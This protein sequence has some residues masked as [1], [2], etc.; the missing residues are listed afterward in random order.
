MDKIQ[1]RIFTQTEA[2]L[3]RAAKTC[4]LF[5]DIAA[6]EVEERCCPLYHPRIKP[7]NNLLVPSSY[8]A[9]FSAIAMLQDNFHFFCC[10]FF[11]TLRFWP[12]IICK[13]ETN[14]ISQRLEWQL[15]LDSIRLQKLCFS[16]HRNVTGC[17]RVTHTSEDTKLWSSTW[18]I[19]SELWPKKLIL[20]YIFM[21]KVKTYSP[22]VSIK[23]KKSIYYFKSIFSK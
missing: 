2:S 1:F 12:T 13:W 3:K 15:H 7:V 8:S 6:K 9:H 23:L 22:E 20:L 18:V 19:G 4:N 10:S 17:K 11:R 21:A 16:Q 5:C 14:Y